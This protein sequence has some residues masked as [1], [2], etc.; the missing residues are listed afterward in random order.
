MTDTSTITDRPDATLPLT[1]NERVVMDEVG[2]GARTVDAPASAVAALA[3]KQT[4]GLGNVDNTSDTDKPVSTAQATALAGKVDSND[5]RLGDART[6]T[7]HTSTHATGGSDALTPADIGAEVA[8]AAA[9]AISAHVAAVDPHPSYLTPAEADAVYAAGD[10]ARFEQTPVTARNNTGTLIAKGTA[11]S[12]AGT[13]GAS[14]RLLIKPTVA[15]GSEPGYVFLG[16]T[17]AAIANGQD[18]VVLTWGKIFN[19][20]TN[21]FNESDILWV[22][23]AV[24][25]GLTATEPAAPNLKLPVAA[26]VNKGVANGILMVRSSIGSR[27]ADLHDVEANGSKSAGDVL[28]WDAGDQRWEP[29]ALTPADIGAATSAQGSLADSAV[30]PGDLATVATSGAYADLSGTPGLVSTSTAGLR[31]ATGFG[32]ITYAATVDLDLAALDSQYRTISL[33]GDLE[34]T[35]SNLANGRTL[36]LRLLCDATER[37]L[38]FPANWVFYSDKPATIAANKGAVLSLTYFGTAD[39]DCVAVYRQQP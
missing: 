2:P 21:A 15:D 22:N 3:T 33:T 8:G 4:V 32:T 38:T 30:Q 19:I 7:A 23:P 29:K 18:G 12:F 28:A 11:V 14:G 36:V 13:L 6:P 17:A 31:A 34:L 20:N 35:T 5:P 24:P 9:S 26:V 25:G 27:L 39:T 1:G 16:I 37:T 10:D